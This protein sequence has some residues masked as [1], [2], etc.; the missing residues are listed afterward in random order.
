MSMA[1]LDSLQVVMNFEKQ[2]TPISS[3][4]WMDN[5]SG[6]IVTSTSKVGALKV[7]NAASD[8]PKDMIK[9][10]PHGI[11]CIVPLKGR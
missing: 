9:V 3:L 1:S 2:S 11:T 4:A 7:W 8:S 6:D 10:G 5:I